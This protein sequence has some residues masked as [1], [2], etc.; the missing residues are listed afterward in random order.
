MEYHSKSEPESEEKQIILIN[1]N[2]EFTFLN[3][4]FPL[5]R[6]LPKPY[7]KLNEVILNLDD[8]LPK[9]Y[10]WTHNIAKDPQNALGYIICHFNI[11][12]VSHSIWDFPKLEYEQV[13]YSTYID[14]SQFLPLQH[15][16]NV[17]AH[18]LW[19]QNALVQKWLELEIRYV[20]YLKPDD[21]SP[22]VLQCLL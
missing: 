2:E 20:R 18:N 16:I 6:H 4:R 1:P 7:I 5:P 10:V 17:T 9:P 3:I 15:L 22:Y 21:L 12:R 19:V 11:D 8:A 14:T 13:Y